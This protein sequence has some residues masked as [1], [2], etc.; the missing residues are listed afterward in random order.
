MA[1]AKKKE[2]DGA[3]YALNCM[4][5]EDIQSSLKPGSCRYAVAED[6]QSVVLCLRTDGLPVRLKIE[7]A[8]YCAGGYRASKW[9][10]ASTG[11]LTESNVAVLG[12]ELHVNDQPYGVPVAMMCH[13]LRLCLYAANR[14]EPPVKRD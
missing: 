14:K 5:A 7:T 6:G 11:K 4:Y 13:L 9:S 10:I 3:V 2:A 12:V 1:E 8:C